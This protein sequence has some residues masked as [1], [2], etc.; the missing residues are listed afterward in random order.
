MS[1]SLRG[2]DPYI[3]DAMT[4]IQQVVGSWGGSSVI[5]SGRRSFEE[6]KELFDDCFRRRSRPTKFPIP[7]CPYP[8]ATPGCSQHEYGF[9]VDAGFFGPPT[10]FGE[11]SDWTGY[12]QVLA[13]EYWGM[14]T[15]PGDPFHFAMYPTSD[16]LPWARSTGQCP[17]PVRLS[18]QRDPWPIGS[19]TRDICG[20]SPDL[21]GSSCNHLSGCTCFYR[22]G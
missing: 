22:D 6:Q 5:I 17:D 7:P 9:A 8:V 16:F 13:R 18:L 3:K 2:V 21:I 19:Q 10:G 4:W 12:A 15:V 1:L 11:I 14:S 20:D